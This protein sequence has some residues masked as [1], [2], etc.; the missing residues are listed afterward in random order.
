MGS[1]IQGLLYG[2]RNTD[3]L[4]CHFSTLAIMNISTLEVNHTDFL[5]SVSNWDLIDLA[6][7]GERTWNTL[8]SL[9]DLMPPDEAPSSPRGEG[10]FVFISEYGYNKDTR[11]YAVLAMGNLV[12][13]PESHQ[14][15][16]GEDT[17]EAINRCLD[18]PD[19]ETR[20]NAAFTL[21]KLTIVE[22]NALLLETWLK[23][24][25]ILIILITKNKLTVFLVSVF[26]HV[27]FNQNPI[28]GT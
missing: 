13:S 23:S 28:F 3:A 22:D 10:H 21:N 9:W 11:R 18:S 15:L 7:T 5:N 8:D 24:S 26:S 17:I 1:G 25:I 12:S 6:F 4:A 2:L 20:F 14:F 19:D 27:V 16:K